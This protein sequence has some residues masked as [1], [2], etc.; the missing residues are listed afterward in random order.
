MAGYLGNLYFGGWVHVQGDGEAAADIADRLA[1]MSSAELEHLFLEFHDELHLVGGNP[2]C[3]LPPLG[4]ASLRQR[5]CDG[6]Q[7]RLQ[8]SSK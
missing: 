3:C 2:H 6:F 8:N 1:R 5:G 4:H 7:E